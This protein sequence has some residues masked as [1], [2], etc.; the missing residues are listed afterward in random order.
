[1]PFALIGFFLAI[2]FNATSIDW[3]K[4]RKL[5]GNEKESFDI[6]AGLQKATEENCI[7]CWFTTAV[8]IPI[9]QGNTI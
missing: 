8:S 1:M 5:A 7:D 4:Y 3:E 2:H 6:A 9:D